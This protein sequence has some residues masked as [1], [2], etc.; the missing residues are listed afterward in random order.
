MKKSNILS[1]MVIGFTLIMVLVFAVGTSMNP[2]AIV[3]A[4]GNRDRIARQ[5]DLL[6]RVQNELLS[7][8]DAGQYYIG[9]FY[10]HSQE[11]TTIMYNHPELADHGLDVI[12][13][14]SPALQALLDGR[15]GT[16]SITRG[17]VGRVEGFLDEFLSY[18][19]PK[20]RQAIY[21]ERRRRPLE[22]MIGLTM[23][24]AWA[25]LNGSQ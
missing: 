16:V 18:A 12:D 10:E 25:Y 19:S 7:T 24:Q 15:G 8:T 13:E 23:D 6:Y 1:R 5:A 4:V 3:F 17:Q 22:N 9:L 14:L 20:L 2:Q 21:D 11:I